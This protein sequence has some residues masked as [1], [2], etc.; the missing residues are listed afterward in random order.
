[1]KKAKLARR[2]LQYPL[3]DA[4]LVP[5]DKNFQTTLTDS[6]MIRFFADVQNK[7]KLETNLRAAGV[8]PTLN[9][10]EV[11]A[12]RVVVASLSDE[13]NPDLRDKGPEILAEVIYNSVMTFIVGEKTIVEMPTFYFPAGAG[14]SPGTA[15]VMNHGQPNPLATFRFS[16]PVYIDKQQNFRVEMRFPQGVP[17]Q[18]PVPGKLATVHGPWR[19]WVVLDGLTRDSQ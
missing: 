1:V 2:R 17:G 3:Y 7:T 18:P 6:R 9:T 13:A 4:F 8:L 14:V 11:L 5:H 19:I 15:I 10:F 12:M 16:E